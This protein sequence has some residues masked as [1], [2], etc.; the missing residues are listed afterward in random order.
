MV[1]FLHEMKGLVD[2]LAFA[3][4]PIDEQGLIVYILT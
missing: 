2:E 3:Q 4:A 1:G